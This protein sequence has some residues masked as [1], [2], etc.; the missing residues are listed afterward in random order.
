MLG[1]NCTRLATTRTSQFPQSVPRFWTSYRAYQT[2]CHT[3]ANASKITCFKPFGCNPVKL[4][5]VTTGIVSLY[6][7]CYMEE[8]LLY[9]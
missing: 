5:I 4:F 7:K 2:P 8:S 1:Y 9:N 6:Q 3:K